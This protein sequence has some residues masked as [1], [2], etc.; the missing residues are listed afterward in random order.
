MLKRG[1]RFS[2]LVMMALL[3][4]VGLALSTD[5][6]AFVS[7]IVNGDFETGNLSG[8]T[9]GGLGGNVEVLVADDFTPT[10][11]VPEGRHFALLSTGPG[12]I[13]LNLGTD[14][15]GNTSPDNDVATL[16]QTFTLSSH[17]V[18]AN[19]SFRWSFLSAEVDGN[20]DFFM[21]TLNGARILTGSVFRAT[22][23][24]SPFPD[25]PPLDGVSYTVVSYGLTD[26]SAFDGGSCGFNNF[27]YI[28]DAPGSYT[29]EFSVADQEDRFFDSGLLIDAV[30][31][32]RSPRRIPSPSPLPPS[33]S[34]P[35]PPVPR[36]PDRF[37]PAQMS[38]QYLNVSPQQTYS[39]QPVTITT[40]VVNNGG[41]MGNYNVVLRIN[42]MTEQSKMVSVSPGAAY[43][44]KFTVYKSRPGTY[45][46]AVDGQQ[47]SFTIL[48]ADARLVGGTSE[49]LLLAIA[50]AV[51]VILSGLL[52]VIAIRRLQG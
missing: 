25:V 52:I 44:V 34:G 19:L 40:N 7:P 31:L 22:M 46:V 11:T 48:S 39:N 21:V 29:L 4:S 1:K 3:L 27:S 20:D 15:D 50:T 47:S 18:P 8:W 42:G 45:V 24:V 13:D 28:I 30:K 16:K 9:V 35:S 49:G 51:I 41:E 6:E 38:V 14:L 43:L 12:E 5:A 32:E 17:Q 37:N 10:I 26:G 33:A 36:Q 2:L 23:F